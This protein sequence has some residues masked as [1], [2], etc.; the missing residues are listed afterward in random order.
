MGPEPAEGSS[1][2]SGGGG[3]TLSRLREA[4]GA[5]EPDSVHAIGVAVAADAL[6]RQRTLVLT[7]LRRLGV[8]IVEARHDEIGTR[9]LDAYLTI[10]R[11]GGIG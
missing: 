5:G 2:C 7:R 9:L 1:A 4:L 3:R 8:D 11:S 10:K 6:A